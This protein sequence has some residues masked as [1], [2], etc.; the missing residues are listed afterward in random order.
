MG[1]LKAQKVCVIYLSVNQ[2]LW[3]VNKLIQLATC[4]KNY[5]K[6]KKIKF[7]IVYEWGF[8]MKRLELWKNTNSNAFQIE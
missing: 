4:L 8:Q 7:C 2:I 6:K 1:K 5:V 3:S